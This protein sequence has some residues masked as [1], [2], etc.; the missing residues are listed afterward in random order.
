MKPVV[1][2][3]CNSLTNLILMNL[4]GIDFMNIYIV[5]PTVTA[6]A[7]LFGDK[8]KDCP[9]HANGKGGY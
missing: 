2:T 8:R 3:E 5:H 4:P 9:P 6:P 7:T 1:C